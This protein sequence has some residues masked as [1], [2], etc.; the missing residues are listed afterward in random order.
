MAGFTDTHPCRVCKAGT[1]V[2]SEVDKNDRRA[3]DFKF[4]VGVFCLDIKPDP[5]NQWEIHLRFSALLAKAIK[6]CCL[7]HQHHGVFFFF[8]FLSGAEWD[9]GKS[10]LVSRVIPCPT[11]YW[12]LSWDVNRWWYLHSAYH[13]AYLLSE[14]PLDYTH[15]RI[16]CWQIQPRI[17]EASFFL[18][19]FSQFAL[20]TW[21]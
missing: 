6:H 21:I 1:P 11:E 8:F 15:L 19:S 4:S 20:L 17:V 3:P 2:L 18:P 12:S 7:T 9:Q 10:L 13:T 16:Y 5:C 14:K